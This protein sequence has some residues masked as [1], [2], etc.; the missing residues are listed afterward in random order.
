MDRRLAATHVQGSS[1]DRTDPQ[2]SASTVAAFTSIPVHLTSGTQQTPDMPATVATSPTPY[3]GRPPLL[4]NTSDRVKV[5]SMM[6]PGQRQHKVAR[7]K[8]CSQVLL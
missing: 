8:V 3:K 4:I 2:A 5:F 7:L 1:V 6:H